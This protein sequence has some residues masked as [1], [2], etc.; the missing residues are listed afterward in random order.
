MEFKKEELVI[1]KKDYGLDLG[2]VYKVLD[3]YEDKID[4][5]CVI[6]NEV[7]KAGVNE[8]T[9]V[10]RVFKNMGQKLFEPYM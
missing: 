10:G 4:V 7:V 5:E 6:Q 8:E 2:R 9:L 3:T 1:L